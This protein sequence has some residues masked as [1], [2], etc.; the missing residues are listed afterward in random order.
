M[1]T[2]NFFK[3]IFSKLVLMSLLVTRKKQCTC[4]AKK[5]FNQNLCKKGIIPID[6]YFEDPRDVA[7]AR[8]NITI[9]ITE[10]GHK[11]IYLIID[12]GVGKTDLAFKLYVF[13]IGLSPSVEIIGIVNGKCISSAMIILAA[14]SK[15]FSFKHST[16]LL[17]GIT[18]RDI[19]LNSLE[20]ELESIFMKKL[21][22]LK[23]ISLNYEN[24]VLSKFSI[25]EEKYKELSN[26]GKNFNRKFFPSKAKENGIID[27]II[28]K[29]PFM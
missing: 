12:S 9:S 28:E 13:L 23:T 20:E 11:K 21:E 10:Y 17:H 7:E 4:Q 18:L 2:K 19:S 3:S 6:F 29:F 16:F 5:V 25:S 26:D 22:D 27:E 15:R 1:K 14:C 8:Q 24:I